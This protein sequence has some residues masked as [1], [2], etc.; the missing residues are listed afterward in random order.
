[1]AA[2]DFAHEGTTVF[3]ARRT[4]VELNCGSLVDREEMK[5]DREKNP[6]AVS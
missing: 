4:Q 1:V 6:R 5:D 3:V 2:R